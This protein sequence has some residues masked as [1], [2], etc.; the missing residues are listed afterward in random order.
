MWLRVLSSPCEALGSIP[1]AD[2]PSKKNKGE[3]ERKN[4]EELKKKK[5][6]VGK[7]RYGSDHEVSSVFIEDFRI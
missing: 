5:K 2:C 6:G 1:N 7:N 4:K 3:K